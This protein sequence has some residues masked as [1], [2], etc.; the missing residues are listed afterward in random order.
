[1]RLKVNVRRRVYFRCEGEADN[2]FSSV[3]KNWIMCNVPRPELLSVRTV[4]SVWPTKLR[5]RR[6]AGACFALGKEFTFYDWAKCV[7]DRPCVCNIY[8]SL[9]LT[10]Y[11][12]YILVPK[13]VQEKRTEV[14]ENKVDRM[15]VINA[16]FE[17]TH[18]KSSTSEGRRQCCSSFLRNL[19]FSVICDK[20]LNITH[21]NKPTSLCC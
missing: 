16:F 20:M 7:F 12:I 5:C 21:Y 11:L 10:L 19:T 15:W 4:D 8:N 13:G 2:F 3:E 1:M 14:L 9:H 18:V 17:W 6:L